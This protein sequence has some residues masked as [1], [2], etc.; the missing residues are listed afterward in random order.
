MRH[1]DINEYEQLIENLYYK[2]YNEEKIYIYGVPKNGCIV[3]ASLSAYAGIEIVDKPE[4]AH[5]IVD[6]LIDSGNTKKRYSKYNKEF[7]TL[8]EKTSSEWIS[9]WFEK[10]VKEEDKDLILRLAQRLEVDLK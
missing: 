5:I 9:F 8:V 3:A 10:E 2:I 1:I 4:R 6:D 7:V